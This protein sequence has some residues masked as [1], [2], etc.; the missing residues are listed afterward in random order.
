MTRLSPSA[1]ERF[2]K[3]AAVLSIPAAAALQL[4][5]TPEA[6]WLVR[7]LGTLACAG[8]WLSSR[9][10][11]TAVPALLVALAPLGP[12]LLLAAGAQPS[13]VVDTIW[14]AGLAGAL[15]PQVSWRRWAL[16]GWWPVL[17]GGWSLTLALGWPVMV[18][19]ESGFALDRLRDVAAINS[20]A[21]LSAPH[22]IGW[23][24]HVVLVQLVGL[25][26]LEWLFA[27]LRT[28]GANGT[29]APVHALWVGATLSSLVAVVQGTVDIS[30][31]NGPEWAALRRA[32]GT[33]LDANAAGVLGALAGPTAAALL[34]QSGRGAPMAILALTINWL[35]LWMSGS[36]TALVCG[37]FGTA[38]W[39]LAVVPRGTTGD[40][41]RPGAPAGWPRRRL[42][43]VALGAVAALALLAWLS[44]AVGPLARLRD[45]GPRET[46]ASLSALVTRGGYGPVALRM[47]AEHPLVGVGPGAFHYLA[48][49]YWRRTED[50]TL[51]FDNA[52]NWWRHQ[53]VEF[54]A[55][56]ALPI[57]AWSLAIAWRVLRTRAPGL[58]AATARGQLLGLG[59][60]SL[61]G[62]PTQNP[63]VLL[64]F[65]GL[66]AVLGHAGPET[67][68][69]AH[70]R[71]WPLTVLPP[72][73]L[74]L[75][76]V[77][78]AGQAV[79]ATG[80]MGVLQ[81][82]LRDKR[83]YISG[84]YA[85]EVSPEGG[86]F[87]W[88][89]DR[90]TLVLPP[91]T[92]W[93]V[94]HLWVAHPDMATDPVTIT[95]SSMCGPVARLQLS[96]PNPVTLGLELPAGAWPADGVDASSALEA[97]PDPLVLSIAVS[98][99]WSP[100]RFGGRDSRQLG[101]GLSWDFVPSAVV[102]RAAD[103]VVSLT[104]CVAGEVP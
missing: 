52:Q 2:G 16:P 77:T 61:L 51:P 20:W 28:T 18:A 26:W 90:A 85:P 33:M 3:A 69:P 73:L 7:L 100:L 9:Y 71:G 62:M 53:L 74:A 55:L 54:G 64:W 34:W 22:V 78:T 30:L 75:A 80:S 11:P 23:T 17:L 43:P 5:V 56:G 10:W 45:L 42:L 6:G 25:I 46:S 65:F 91:R 92:P 60:I 104:P 4:V 40:A 95:V 39:V 15:L 98:R 38:A 36:R 59:V 79:L 24:L 82:A 81:R 102:A 48:P 70:P 89:R 66:V 68:P 50:Y 41:R 12:A 31:L 63:V 76:L 72:L 57:L 58:L 97:R 101:A 96:G 94:M 87:R 99:T 13:P 14:L 84:T 103:Q 1:V 49:D 29:P 44:S 47:F 21:G 86:Q 88:T 27:R 37:V 32:T 35:G 67:A 83:L 93:L 19:R 8:G